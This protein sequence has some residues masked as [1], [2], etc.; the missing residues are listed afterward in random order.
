MPL[1]FLADRNLGK[2][3]VAALREAR[4]T[5]HTLAD[6]FGETDSQLVEDTSWIAHAGSRRWACLTKDRRIRHV[7]LEREC[8]VDHGVKLFALANANLNFADMIA[9]FLAA[10]RRMAELCADDGSGGQIW[11]VQR[12]GRLEVVWPQ[13][14]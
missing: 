5:V 9:A 12:D 4:L 10:R 11:V 6:V 2:R 1:E 14:D 13:P 3:V 8:V 7:T